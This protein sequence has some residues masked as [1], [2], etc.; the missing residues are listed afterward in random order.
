[1]K[2]NYT[3]LADVPT[4]ATKASMGAVRRSSAAAT[5]LASMTMFNKQIVA[6]IKQ[7]I[8]YLL[9]GAGVSLLASF[10]NRMIRRAQEFM[11]VTITIDSKDKAFESLLYFLSLQSSIKNTH[12]LSAETVYNS[13]GKNPTIIFVPAVGSHKITYRS[14]SI[15]VERIREST[16]D[17]GSGAPFE[18]IALTLWGRDSSLVQA[19]VD[20]AI[21][22]ASSRDEGKTVVYI[23]SGA[24]WERFG[25]PRTARSLGSVI[26]PAELKE[27]L[28]RDI[29]DFIDGEQW[30]RNRGIPYRRGY[31]LHGPP[32]N[33][34]SSLVNAIAGELN[35]DICIVSLSDKGMDDRTINSLLNNAPPKSILLIEDVDAAFVSRD[36]S[37]D[38]GFQ[39]LTFS[40]VLNALDGVASQEGRILFMT[41]NHIELLDAALIRDGRI[42]LRLNISNATRDQAHQLFCHFYSLDQADHNLADQFANHITDHQLSMSQIQGFLLQYKSSPEEAA[43][44]A[45]QI[46]P[47]QIA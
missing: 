25:N 27:Q 13:S 4:M 10:A 35:L 1:M 40:G 12:Q 44:N 6:G 37:S 22:A 2:D 45:H 33:G 14:R 28:V 30:F 3:V 24:A 21:K 32:G 5:S 29:R 16:F 43:K 41:T 47:V 11:F 20:E 19:L 18:S 15:W 23:N 42:D 36:K 34:K 38:A 31:L 46:Q 7:G 26:L 39:S 8:G 17:M 9:V